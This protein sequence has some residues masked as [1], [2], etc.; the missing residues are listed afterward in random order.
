MVIK[1]FS[2]TMVKQREELAARIMEYVRANPHLAFVMDAKLTSDASFHCLTIT[3]FGKP[4]VAHGGMIEGYENLRIFSATKG[5]D[6]EILGDVIGDIDDL[7][8]VDVLQ[9]SDE[10]FHCLVYIIKEH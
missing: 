4:S 8:D 10:G 1:T 7:S 6:R 9:S 2:V 5:K 3:L